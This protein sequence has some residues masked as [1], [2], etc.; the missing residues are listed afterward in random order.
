MADNK[1]RILLATIL[2]PL[3]WGST[4]VIFTQTL[5][6]EHPLLVGA[7]RA[8]PAGIL[9]M[10]LGP[11][12]PPRDKLLPLAIIGFANI[13]L[14]FG[15]LFLSASRLPGGLAAT[16]G[17]MQPLLVA[18]L[19]WP[20]LRR[21]RL[22]QVLAALAGTIGVGLLVIDNTVKL[23]AIGVAAALVGAASMATGTVLIE[24][25][26][27]IGSPLALAAWQLTLGG[28]L[29]LPVALLVEGLPP[30][31][32]MRNL[33][34]LTYLVVIGTAFA[35]WLWVRGIATIGTG[36]AFL[37]LLSPLVATFLGA[38]LLGEWFHAQQWL[39]IAIIF[40]STVAG[41]LLSRRKPAE[42]A[43]PDQAATP[44]R[45][46]SQCNS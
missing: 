42:A 14:F 21:P 36:V 2:A 26:G 43:A 31:P 32:T 19:A 37:S 46:I 27:K 23:D 6:V 45:L 20:L 12:L 8:L 15:M 18:F 13:G 16:L 17:S 44:N 5:P 9:L 1:T 40:G 24:R 41:I 11:G 35:Y 4:Y 7:L 33:A 30:V 10:L 28:L 38:A 3:L 25:W 29:L 39:G 34:G 22:G